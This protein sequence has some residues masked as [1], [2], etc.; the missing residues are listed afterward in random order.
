MTNHAT[1]RAIAALLLA[2]CLLPRT[3]AQAP[4]P[5]S[6]QGPRLVLAHYMPGFPALGIDSANTYWYAAQYSPDYDNLTARPILYPTGG[7]DHN[8]ESRIAEIRV[9]KAYGIDGFL[10]DQL[11]DN[12]TFRTTW[13]T[14]LRAAEIVGNFKIGLQPDYATL[15]N[16]TGGDHPP[17]TRRDKIKHWLDIA[18]DSPALL[19]FGGKPVVIPYGAAYPDAK[20]YD[21]DKS[22][23]APEGEKRD[24][25]DWMRAQGT[26]IAYAAS[27]SLGWPIY[28]QPY[29]NDPKT[30]FQT[31][32]FATATFSPGDSV[33][34]LAGSIST[35]Q[36]A[37]NYWPHDFMQI[38]EATFL[39][40]NPHAHWYTAPRLSTT[41]RQDWA[42]NVA[43]RDRI[44]WVEIITW[45][46]WGESAIAPSVN[47]FMALQPITRYYADWF[48]SGHPSV[49]SKDTV[50]ILHRATPFAA[51]PTKYPTRINGPA[52]TDEVEA[53][54]MLKAP[55]TLILKSGMTEYR[56]RVG[57]GIQSLIRPFALGVQ[58]ARVER[59]GK[60]VA[61]VTSP[62][63]IHDKPLRENLWIDGATSAFPPRPIRLND[64]T[65]S[66]GDWAGT[67]VK[68]TGTGLSLVGDGAQL[69]NISVSAFVAPE[70][71]S[72]G[73][74]VGVVAHANGLSFYRL[75]L[76]RWEGR[77]QWRLSKI[78][79]GKETTL[80]S[81]DTPDAAH[82]PRGLRLDCVGEHLIPYLD[83]RLLTANVSDYP[84]WQRTPM[85]YGQVG[86][87]AAGTR[88]V[89]TQISVKSYDPE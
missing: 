50:T 80:A 73:D 30:G 61:A 27:H 69:G 46:D 4:V 41:W 18:R 1:C 23:T 17:Q 65:T 34:T 54:A 28:T 51:V 10:V 85:T 14:L 12:V 13:T 66:S 3:P 33:N 68:R 2:L 67:G 29:A 56:Q 5:S 74:F 19:R 24:L 47:H 39:Y 64:W 21:L 36:R 43:H 48:K 58:S 53:L 22:L 89:F 9:A 32:A 79:Q 81:G 31:F 55:A 42:W 75:A 84:D 86:I 57:A 87:T 63:P 35:R 62:I 78:D 52:P 88:A 15:N 20:V 40:M 82:V 38:G 83:G 44:H 6:V 72:D 37:L 60:V 45:N 77:G 49:I 11:E 8:L 70:A 25:V 76:G 26:P 7:T 71:V 16:P 59:H